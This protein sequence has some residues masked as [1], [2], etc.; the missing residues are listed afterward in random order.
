M[1][2]EAILTGARDSRSPCKVVIL[3]EGVEHALQLW[4]RH[5]HLRLLT[6][7]DVW[8][9]NFPAGQQQLFAQAT[10]TP[11]N[12][13]VPTIVTATAMQDLDLTT[14]D[15]LIRADGGQGL[16]PIPQVAS[17]PVSGSFCRRLLLI[18]CDDRHHPLRHK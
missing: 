8:A 9:E 12:M 6:G 17:L 4:R 11:A 14:I 3:I 16:P 5:H 18:D 7:P 1:L 10:S 13:A 2:E 15:V